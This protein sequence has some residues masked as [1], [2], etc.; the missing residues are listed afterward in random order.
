MILAI[1]SSVVF[2][3]IVLA[4][5]M[6]IYHTQHMFI[7]GYSVIGNTVMRKS[8]RDQPERNVMSWAICDLV[9]Q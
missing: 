4:V 8:T 7:N 5:Q 6:H 1:N 3:N 9:L 2:E